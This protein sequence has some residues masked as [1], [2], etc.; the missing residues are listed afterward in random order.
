M[1][2]EVGMTPEWILLY[3]WSFCYCCPLLTILKWSASLRLWYFNFCPFCP[4]QTCSINKK[5]KSRPNPKCLKCLKIR[6]VDKEW[7][8]KSKTHIF[9]NPYQYFYT[10]SLQCFKSATQMKNGAQNQKLSSFRHVLYSNK[11]DQ[12]TKKCKNV[13]RN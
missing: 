4:L 6:N 11:K 13:G 5:T 12:S 3:S 7:L 8:T 10:K 2:N 9:E 1:E